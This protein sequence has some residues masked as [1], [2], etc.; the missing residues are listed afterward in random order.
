MKKLLLASLI[1][2]LLAVPLLALADGMM[3]GPPSKIIYEKDQ[4]AVIFYEDGVETLIL[5]VTFKGDTKDFAWIVPTPKRPEVDKSSDEL[6]EKLDDLTE[7]EFDYE[8]N[9][10]R[11]GFFGAAGLDGEAPRVTVIETKKVAYYDITV[12]ESN[13]AEALQKWLLEHDY[14]YPKSGAHILD[15]YIKE[16]WY[17]TAVK[18]DAS[19]VHFGVSA[20][21]KEGHAVP[22]KLI[23]KTDRIVY[24]LKISSIVHD[25]TVALEVIEEK[26]EEVTET[27]E[28]SYADGNL[29]KAYHSQRKSNLFLDAPTDYDFKKGAMELWFYPQRWSTSSKTPYG[30][31]E[32]LKLKNDDEGGL[33]LF[34]SAGYVNISH[35]FYDDS[36]GKRMQ[37][38]YITRSQGPVRFNY[39]DWNH[40][41]VSWNNYDEA[42]CYFNGQAI[43]LIS[44]LTKTE[45]PIATG[46]RLEKGAFNIAAFNSE[47]IYIDESRFSKE[48]RTEDEMKKS[49][50][51]GQAIYLYPDDKTL[52]VAHFENHLTAQRRLKVDGPLEKS[53]FKYKKEETVKK[54][55]KKTV[56]KTR[57][58]KPSKVG[59]LIYVFAKNRHELTGFETQYAGWISKN[60]IQS[61][62]SEDGGGP[63]IEPKENKYFLTRLY[64]SMPLSQMTYDLYPDQA[65]NN[66]TVNYVA[67]VDNNPLRMYV[68]MI[69]GVIL[70]VIILLFLLFYGKIKIRKPY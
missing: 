10:I 1:L 19:S 48:A 40:V 22:L 53:S 7:V 30:Y 37:H 5:S 2:C 8:Y 15:D 20:Q 36:S 49:Y 13:N 4:K 33:G 50:N 16:G 23:F 38:H 68:I 27:G 47:E 59:I 25:P 18:I 55:V 63:W 35:R 28:A 58:N 39:D 44:N 54:S 65:K 60:K 43:P 61:L 29:G 41:A 32:L 26:Q 51:N 57:W 31:L 70:T 21:L 6:F 69:I 11:G 9:Q 67:D 62:A 66:E 45:A 12:L 24:P 42:T 34:I 64:K 3:V 46:S 56:T 14:L 52:W 17:F